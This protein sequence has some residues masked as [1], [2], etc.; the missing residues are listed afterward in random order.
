MIQQSTRWLVVSFILSGC[1]L[2][3]IP[4]LEPEGKKIKLVREADKPLDCEVVADVSGTARA[5]DEKEA[6]KG[7]ENDIRNKAAEYEANFAVVE[8]ERSHNAGTGPYKEVFLGGKALK[9]VTFEMQ[10]KKEQQ[11]A[12][13]KERAEQEEAERARQEELERTKEEAEKEAE[14][15]K[16]DE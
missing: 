16:D 6:I 13:A 12:E 10:A 11:E 5:E 9:C 14:D 15:K 3:N 8:I 1:V 7:A 2:Q 4:A